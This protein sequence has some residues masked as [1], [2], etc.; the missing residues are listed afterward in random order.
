VSEKERRESFIGATGQ[1]AEFRRVTARDVRQNL[2][3][4]T[5]PPADL[6]GTAR[7]P[8]ISGPASGC[9]FLLDARTSPA[10]AD[11]EMDAERVQTKGCSFCLDNFGAYVAPKE[12]DAVAAWLE[13]LRRIRKERPDAREVVLTDERPHRALQAFFEA[14]ASEPGLAP[15][16]LLWKS[17]ADWL[18]EFADDVERACAI[19]ERSGSVAH[20]YL[21]GF[22]NFDRAH[23]ALFN[24]GHGPEVNEA[25]IAKMRELQERY[26]RSFEHRKY[27]SHGI[28]L[29]TPWTEPEAL[30]ENARWMRRLR[31]H[32]L[33]AEAVKT[34][35]RLY[36]RV[37]LHRL[38]ER[39]GL[40]AER[41]EEG[42]GDRALEQG[43][44]A[45]V[46][47][48]FRDGRTEAVFQLANALHAA[49]PSITDADLIEVA[50]RFVLRWPG[51]ASAP[52]L[53]HLPVRAAVEAWGAPLS[54]LLRELGPAAAAFDP[55]VEAIGKTKKRA[56]LK[57]SV[58]GADAEEMAAAYRAMGLA[59]AVVLRHTMEKPT[60]AHGWGGAEAGRAGGTRVA[61]SAGGAE[62]GRAGGT[63]VAVSA[64]GGDHAIIAVA[65]DE[66]AL[67]E[68]LAAQRALGA[69]RG[70]EEQA[71]AVR[72]LGALMGYPACCVEAFAELGNRGDNLENERLPFLRR[73]EQALH[74]LLHRTGA[75][76]LIAH[77]LCSPGC[78]ASIERAEQVTALLAA[79]DAE[80]P[81]RL[82]AAMRVPSLFL[83]YE[84]FASV[85][86]AWE[87]DAFR[88]QR[89]LRTDRAR[90]L[91]AQLAA[92]AFVRVTREGAT[93]SAANGG[94]RVIAAER[95]LLAVPGEP[96]AAPALAAITR[97]GSAASPKKSATKSAASPDVAR[98]T[99]SPG[100]S[101]ALPSALRPGVRV[102]A[103]VIASIES[104]AGGHTVWLA[105][106]RERVGVRVRAH[107]DGTPYTLR[108]GRWAV[109]VEDAQSLG[110]P[111]RAA[112]GLLVRALPP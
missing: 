91:E 104:S 6:G 65:A 92:A 8:T 25:A 80:A 94:E 77:H 24:K 99:P 48:R 45:S 1:S 10:F 46:P 67:A 101:P 100:E 2:P 34:R 53:A 7:R 32:E 13:G 38:A 107:R 72:A 44:D 95:P 5:P 82:V 105:R 52:S 27:R 89:V 41:F 74:P 36:P 51:L 22:E 60:G 3:V 26:P 87:G 66:A 29:F 64:G 79:A 35:L 23:L 20:L 98:D 15:V 61:V 111:A 70:S 102:A 84:R 11:L 110:E 85:E 78:A 96:I 108:K 58:R 59:A 28:V 88:V 68:V 42:R 97:P 43:Y 56:A 47:W 57:E 19:A 73:P 106:D 4:F 55:E 12:A 90:E 109:D 93:L 49:D 9:P 83:D 17:R 37:P 21:M 33:R 71:S 16:E 39:D 81:A 30:I 112:I 75:V 103:Y 14:I 63:R 31:F 69:T 86:G 54:F 62:P 40:L 76:R 50:A 18:L